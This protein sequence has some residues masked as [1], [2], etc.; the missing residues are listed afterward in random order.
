MIAKI[1]TKSRPV[2]VQTGNSWVS[3][4]V[5]MRDGVYYTREVLAPT[6]KHGPFEIG[7]EIEIEPSFKDRLAEGY[8]TLIYDNPDSYEEVM[9]Q[10][11]YDVESNSYMDIDDKKEKRRINSRICKPNPI[12]DAIIILTLLYVLGSILFILIFG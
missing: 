4:A 11:K 5:Y 3:D 6:L 12:L 2:M 1:V 7:E 9:E 8:M 10:R